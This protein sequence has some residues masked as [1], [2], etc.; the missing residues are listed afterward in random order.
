M[1]TM[2]L[3]IAQQYVLFLSCFIDIN[4]AQNIGT[5]TF[6][7]SDSS[8]SSSTPTNCE[9]LSDCPSYQWLLQNDDAPNLSASRLEE[10]IATR[11]C[12][13]S[14][15]NLKIEC[16]AENEMEAQELPFEDDYIAKESDRSLSNDCGGSLTI[17]HY[18]PDDFIFMKHQ[19]SGKEYHNLEVL[20][21]RV[22]INIENTGRC[23]WEL[24]DD[25]DFY[26][27][28]QELYTRYNKA[29]NLHPK[30]IRKITC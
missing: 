9:L 8:F 19:L 22:I 30:S 14:G 24:F 3:F 7:F 29:P 5:G 10:D 16:P 17:L 18:G 12:G 13:S 6:L 1:N 11:L 26:G 23:C 4:N 25:S 2:T 20:N 21:G 28:S 15:L 27:E